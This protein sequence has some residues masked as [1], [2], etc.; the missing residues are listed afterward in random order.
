MEL[1]TA[2]K[3]IVNLSGTSILKEQRLVNILAD[4]NAYDDIPSAKFIIKTIIDEGFMEKFLANGKW[5]MNCNKLIDQFVAMTGVAKDNVNYVFE[6]LGVSLGWNCNAPLIH[7]VKQSFP[8]KL[9]SNLSDIEKHLASIVE[10]CNGASLSGFTLANPSVGKRSDNEIIVGCEVNGKFKGRD[11]KYF[12]VQCSIYVNGQINA[13]FQ[14]GGSINSEN[15]SGFTIVSRH[16]D[17]QVPLEDL[18][19]IVI[20]IR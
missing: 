2:L 4:F 11:Y 7:T 14:M 20:Y 5:D 19:R 12:Y 17:V 9:N 18:T 3:N 16:I 15:F 6:S 1:H 13:T 10:V 8:F